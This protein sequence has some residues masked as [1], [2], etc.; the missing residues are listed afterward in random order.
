M[1]SSVLVEVGVSGVRLH[2]FVVVVFIVVND[3]SDVNV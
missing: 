2:V 1:L 3:D